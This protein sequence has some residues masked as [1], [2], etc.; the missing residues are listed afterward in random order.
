MEPKFSGY[1]AI[2]QD[3]P[4]EIRSAQGKLWAEFCQA[5]ANRLR[6][7]IMYP[8][9]LIVEGRIVRDE[10]PDWNQRLRDQPS[11]NPSSDQQH[12]D[13]TNINRDW[14]EQ[15]RPRRNTTLVEYI[16]PATQMDNRYR[17]RTPWSANTT[18]PP[19]SNNTPPE[20]LSLL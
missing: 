3:F 1:R 17:L 20:T 9:K 7:S 18:S 13:R 10:L 4:A 6:A 19:S 12:Q 8:A 11:S 16:R 5:K 14:H 15:G 2:Q